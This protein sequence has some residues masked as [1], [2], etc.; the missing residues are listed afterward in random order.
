MIDL[1][2]PDSVTSIGNHAFS[3]CSSLASVSIPASVM[4]IG[5]GSFRYCSKLTSVIIPKS[6]TSIGGDV[7]SGCGG[8]EELT[9]PFIGSQRGNTGSSD[10]MF[11]YI[12]GLQSYTG[13]LLC[14]SPG[15]SRYYIPSKLRKVVVTDET[16]LG[17][18]AFYGCSGLTS[19]TISGSVV[20]IGDSAFQNCKS[21]QHV[22]VPF[23]FP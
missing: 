5:H 19:V 14:Y 20:S 2:I 4:S 23:A 7:F 10:S 18:G 1:V 13:G 9:L 15:G 21:L 16:I 12:F 17:Y 6:V 8:L 11:C 3:G 22:S